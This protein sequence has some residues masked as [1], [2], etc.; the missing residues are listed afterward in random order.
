MANQKIR[1]SPDWNDR[2]TGSTVGWHEADHPNQSEMNR[3]R[4]PRAEPETSNQS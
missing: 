3:G 1:N 4:E 2:E